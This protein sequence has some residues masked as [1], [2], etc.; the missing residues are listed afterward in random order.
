MCN[1]Y[2][3]FFLFQCDV[4]ILRAGEHGQVPSQIS[5]HD[6]H[7]PAAHPDDCRLLHQLMGSQLHH[8]LDRLLRH[9][10]LQH[11]T[12]HGHVLLL[13]RPLRPLLLQSLPLTQTRQEGQSRARHRHPQLQEELQRLPTATEWCC[14]PLVVESCD[15]C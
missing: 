12:L 2:S 6:H 14:R 4:L 9:Q 8:L 7:L 1:L 13:L 11:Q 15:M 3:F 5:G 10:P